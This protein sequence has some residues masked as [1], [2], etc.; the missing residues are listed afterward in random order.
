MFAVGIPWGG[1]ETEISFRDLFK[2]GVKKI[3]SI[4]LEKQLRYICIRMALRYICMY[5]MLFVLL[6]LLL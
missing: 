4:V 1:G 2:P 3:V 5:S 6:L